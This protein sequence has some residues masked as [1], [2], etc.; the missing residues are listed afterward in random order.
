MLF[1]TDN[2]VRNTDMSY[3]YRDIYTS[4]FQQIFSRPSN[5]CLFVQLNVSRWFYFRYFHAALFVYFRYF[6]VI[7]RNGQLDPM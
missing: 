7:F 5:I 6:H 2:G 3:C 4:V 1:A